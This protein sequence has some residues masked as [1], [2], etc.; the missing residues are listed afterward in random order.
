[1]HGYTDM[2]PGQKNKDEKSLML[3]NDKLGKKVRY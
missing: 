1:M 3:A 2:L